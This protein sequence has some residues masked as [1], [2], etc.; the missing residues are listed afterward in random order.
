MMRF[1]HRS[2][3][4]EPMM[5]SNFFRRWPIVLGL[6]MVAGLVSQAHAAETGFELR[7]DGIIRGSKEKKRIALEFT[8]DSFAEGGKTILDE[9]AKRK[10]KGSFFFTGNF[11]RKAEFKPL[12]ERIIKDGHYVGPHSDKHLLYCPWDG[13]KKTLIT[14]EVFNQ[15]L[16]RNLKEIE[17]FG[18]KRA[19]LPYW[20]PPY[21]HYNQEI[22][23][24]SADMGTIVINFTPGTRSAADY[25]GEADKNFVSSQTIYDS[26]V[27]KEKEDPKGLNGFLLLMHIGAGPK[28]TDKFYNRLGEL[29]EYLGGKGY[30]FVRVDELLGK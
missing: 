9:L 26:I 27:K 24:W 22:V 7:D 17:K 1:G 21:E 11:F 13:T 4:A 2:K 14:H 28:R 18:L 15:D 12:I 10:A 3:P 23:K 29:M 16:E 20:I 6:A 19:D 5:T 25:T 30:E 8:G